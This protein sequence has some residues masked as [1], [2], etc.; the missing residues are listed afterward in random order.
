MPFKLQPSVLTDRLKTTLKLAFTAK[1]T[2]KLFNKPLIQVEAKFTVKLFFYKTLKKK[3]RRFS[4]RLLWRAI[5]SHLEEDTGR[6]SGD[7]A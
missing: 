5:Q 2:K 6:E 7:D 1:H 4:S 3:L